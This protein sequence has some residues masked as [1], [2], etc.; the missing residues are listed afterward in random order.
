MNIDEIM[1]DQNSPVYHQSQA[2]VGD[3]LQARAGA[4]WDTKKFREERDVT[5]SKLSDQNFNPAD[6][7][8]PLSPRTTVKAAYLRS[9]PAGTEERLKALVAKV[10]SSSS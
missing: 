5:K 10:E 1:S 7:P 6:Y 8:D 9:F 4:A 2:G 3:D